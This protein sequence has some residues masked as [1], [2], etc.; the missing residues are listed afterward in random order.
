MISRGLVPFLTLLHGKTPV[1]ILQIFCLS[2]PAIFVLYINIAGADV[3]LANSH[4][5]TP[6]YISA[7]EGHSGVMEHVLRGR[8]ELN[9][10]YSR[11][12]LTPLMASV[13]NERLSTT[14]MLIKVLASQCQAHL[15]M[16]DHQVCW[17]SLSFCKDKNITTKA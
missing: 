9:G 3:N 8:A 16:F 6:L 14:R 15:S 12:G 10:L 4:G 7:H 5:E 17:K 1:D 13:I 11:E 2:D